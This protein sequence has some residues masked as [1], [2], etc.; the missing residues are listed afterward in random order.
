[1]NLSEGQKRA[2]EQLRE[3]E[4]AAGGLFTVDAVTQPDGAGRDLVAEITVSCFELERADGGLPLEDRER[5]TILIGPNF[6]FD[7]PR[8]WVRH[9]RFAGFSHV[10]WRCSLC[11]YQAPASEWNPSDGMFGFLDRLYLFLKQGAL[12]QLDPVGAA[13]HPPVTYHSKG[14]LRTVIPRVDA[15]AVTKE[16]WFGT[17]HLREL[18]DIRVDIV[19]WSGLLDQNTPS[20]VAAAILLPSAFPYEFPTRVWDLIVSLAERGVSR[21][22]LLLTLQWAAI[23]NPEQTPLYV[24]VGTPMRGMRGGELRQHLTAWY[25]EP[26]LAWG[27]KK[28]LDKHSEDEQTRQEGATVEQLVLDWAKVASVAWCAVREDRPEIVSRRDAGTT[29]AWFANRTV[30]VWS[31]GALGGHVAEYLTRA[32]AKKLILR[33]NGIVTPG[34]LVRQPFD[35]ADIGVPKALAL[36]DRVGRIRPELD[37]VASTADLLDDLAGDGDWAMGAEIVIDATASTPVLGLLEQRRWRS[38]HQR[39]PVVSMAIGR[40]ADRAMVVVSPSVHSGGPFDLCRRLKLESCNN[41]KLTHY[42]DEFWPKVRLPFFQ[43]EPGCSDATFVGSAADVAGLAALMLNRAAADLAGPASQGTATGH[44][45]AQPHVQSAERTL[46]ASFIWDSDQISA[47]IHAGY[48]VRISPAAWAEVE[49]WIGR[50][51]D[52]AGPKVETGGL[53][54]GERDDAALVIWVSEVSGPPADSSASPDGFVCGVTGTAEMNNQKRERS[55]GSVQY[56]GMWHTHPDALPLPSTTDFVAIRR[57]VAAAGGAACVLMLI[58]G[59]PDGTPMLGTYVFR[60]ADLRAPAGSVVLR[61]CV[62]RVVDSTR[63]AARR[64]VSTAKDALEGPSQ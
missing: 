47:D 64:Q 34:V 39:V 42:L 43:P 50:S 19:G 4:A 17:A 23:H 25:I 30:A 45:L 1:M 18:S 15:P 36:R 31:C 55:R 20:G 38:G 35:D 28:A 56:L 44:F 46:T 16:G 9:D 13:L 62:I 11:L 63:H 51:R 21:Q 41:P 37:V 8:A 58:V 27:L 14:P 6:P 40:N 3:V 53:L 59:S 32:G 48:Q 26:L 61:P 7:L 2:L 29:L 10:Q 54:F 49:S 24:L 33:D 57:L 22:Q 5:F 52:S 12:G 60:A